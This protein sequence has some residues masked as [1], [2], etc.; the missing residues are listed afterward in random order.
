[1]TIELLVIAGTPHLTDA[2]NGYAGVEINS[3]QKLDLA[4]RLIE[5]GHPP[6]AVYI[7][8]TRGTVDDLWRAVSAAQRRGIPIFVGVQSVALV[9][10]RDFEDAG[11]PV[12]SARD[13]A[14]IATWLGQQ[15]QLQRRASA[16]GQKLIAIG[17][18]KGGIGKT[19]LVALLA[20]GFQRRGLK[21][22]V[23]D[24]DLSN[25]GLLPTFRLQS[26]FTSYLSIRDEGTA[27][28]TPENVR[29]AI[30]HHAASGIDFLLGS[31]ETASAQDLLLPQ[32]QAFMQAVRGLHEYPV[33]ILD[34]GPEFLKRPYALIAVRDGG[35]AVLPI[36]PGRKERSGA[37]N[38]LRVFQ[39]HT[40]DLTDRCHLLYMEPERGVTVSV[41]QVA[42]LFAQNF[43]RTHVLGVLPRAP[44]V[45]SIADEDGDR[46]IS[47]LDVA[48]HSSFSRAVHGVVDA[49]CH[50][51]ELATPLPMPRSS[52]WQRLR[53]E[54][55]ALQQ[56]QLALP[57]PSD[58]TG[59]ADVHT[60]APGVV[61]A[62]GAARAG[63]DSDG[64]TH[65]AGLYSDP[66]TALACYD[67]MPLEVQR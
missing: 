57:Q 36:P 45:V 11:I 62:S 31:E 7:E 10:Q 67:D 2:M 8:D 63:A 19:L 56:P 40:P 15:L 9:Q 30:T 12:T 42:P 53:G 18:A 25:S 50:T 41:D 54:Q 66:A 39:A 21:V 55:I 60:A 6:D 38:A 65:S 27:G 47:P 58:A 44:R 61:P 26:G 29:R 51:L 17:G 1:M 16:S 34:T 64:R 3:G 46:Y 20:Q 37:G 28:W 48:P 5:S 22:L 4:T 23:V 13:A 35:I 49:L 14:T 24:G 32:W 52:W 43:P 33:V 59:S